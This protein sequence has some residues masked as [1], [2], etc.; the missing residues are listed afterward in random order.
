M[1]LR[2]VE[3]SARRCLDK[4]CKKVANSHHGRGL[5]PGPCRSR[6]IISLSARPYG[7][8]RPNYPCDDDNDDGTRREM[9]EDA[10]IAALEASFS[11]SQVLYVIA[12]LITK[13][14]HTTPS[15][16]RF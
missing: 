12:I 10:R 1:R 6:R 8:Y 2:A 5:D 4:K 9:R 15:S 16:D 13:K 11:V 14:L 3:Y 7:P